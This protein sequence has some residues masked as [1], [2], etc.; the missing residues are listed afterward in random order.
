MLLEGTWALHNGSRNYTCL[1]WYHWET[2]GIRRHNVS[3]LCPWSAILR[4]KL[5]VE[6]WC[7]FNYTH[8][9]GWASE[10]QNGMTKILQGW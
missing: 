5:C 4:V 6:I 10:S 3:T 2:V 7:A 9:T 8:V 1:L